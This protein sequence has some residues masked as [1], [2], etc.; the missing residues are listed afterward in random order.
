MLDTDVCVHLIRKK[1]A[2]LLRK[3][4]GYVMSDIGISSITVA[5]LQYGVQKSSRPM[6][7]QQ[8]LDQ[9]LIPLSIV[10]FDY[11]AAII[12]GYIRAHLEAQG[13]MI[14]SLDSL[15]AAHALSRNFTLVTNNTGEFSRVPGLV[16][17][18]WLSS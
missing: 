5:A 6:Q 16:V 17:D 18:N 8:A 13:T 2:D 10:D 15:I 4:T 9:F 14:G 7:N 3:L 12:Y 11:D 1:P